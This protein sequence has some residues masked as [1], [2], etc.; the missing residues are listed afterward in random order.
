MLCIRCIFTPF[1]IISVIKQHKTFEYKYCA[2]E[3]LCC[4]N[5][6]QQFNADCKCYYSLQFNMHHTYLKTEFYFCKKQCCTLLM[7]F[8]FY[9]NTIQTT[10]V[11]NK[12]FLS[13]HVHNN[14]ENITCHYFMIIYYWVH[15]CILVINQ[16]D[17]MSL[18]TDD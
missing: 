1:F 8:S 4:Y 16:R 11:M 5:D 2:P 12:L 10:S 7:C 6:K 13:I 3:L 17:K 14:Y 9:T 18:F 15:F